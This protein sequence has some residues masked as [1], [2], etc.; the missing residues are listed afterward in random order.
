[1]KKLILFLLWR[2]LAEEKSGSKHE[3]KNRAC[4]RNIPIFNNFK[5]LRHAA[6]SNQLQVLIEAADRDPL[7]SAELVEA[8]FVAGGGPVATFQLQVLL[9]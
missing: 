7:V 9:G 6:G 8:A 2:I 3:E 5:R 4:E 1:M